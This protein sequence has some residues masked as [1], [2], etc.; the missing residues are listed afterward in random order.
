MS[1]DWKR[2]G[3]VALCA[4]LAFLIIVELFLCHFT[5]NPASLG[6]LPPAEIIALS[7]GAITA[8]GLA[9]IFVQIDAARRAS[10]ER[11]DQQRKDIT[12]RADQLH[13]D[14]NTKEMRD[15]RNRAY[16]YLKFLNNDANRER[17]RRLDSR[18]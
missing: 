1:E 9:A 7:T 16:H 10:T 18:G 13:A 5:C 8:A 12:C 15:H 11:E 4:G 2:T 3:I 6:S 14:F 17:I